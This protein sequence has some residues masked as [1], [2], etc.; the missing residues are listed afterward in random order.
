M[1]VCVCVCVK[2]EQCAQFFNLTLCKKLACLD[3]CLGNGCGGFEERFRLS[4]RQLQDGGTKHL[5]GS[6][7]ISTQGT[8]KDSLQC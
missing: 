5:F 4:G 8:G 7:D 2:N 3:L 6:H 1:C